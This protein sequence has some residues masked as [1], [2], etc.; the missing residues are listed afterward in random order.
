MLMN[1][2]SPPS[3]L[4]RLFALDP[5]QLTPLER[6]LL[7]TA[8][9]VVVF[10][11][12]R[13]YL[14]IRM[15]PADDLR[16]RVVGARV[17]LAGYEPYHFDWQPGM[18][19]EWLDPVHDPKARR[20]TLSPPMLL[21]YALIAPVPFRLQRYI[22]FVAEWLAMI[23]SLC[24][25]AHSLPAPRHRVIFLLGA[26]VFVIATD[27]WRIHLERGQM[28]VFVLLA[29]SVAIYAA[30]EHPDSVAGGVAFGA[31]ALMRPNLLCILPALLLVRRW[32]CAGAMTATI[33]AGVVAACALLPWSSWP[34]YIAVGDQYFA[35]AQDYDAMP[36]IPRPA[37]EGPVEGMWFYSPMTNFRSNSF[38]PIY[39]F[40]D[41]W[42]N[43]FHVV[44]PAGVEYQYGLPDINLALTSKV[45]MV[46]LA[47]LLSG[48]VWLRRTASP[49]SITAL[50]IVLSLDTEFF[51]PIRWG[52]A[53]M[54]LL[55]P[56]ALFLPDLLEDKNLWLLAVVLLGLLGGPLG[57][58]VFSLDVATVLRSWLVMGGLTALAV[59]AV[60]AP[61]SLSAPGAIG[62]AV[63]NAGH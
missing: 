9:L 41:Q 43:Q 23:A 18:P 51:L 44:D 8:L 33:A 11:I 5:N 49:R 16:N 15:N 36:D 30:R 45:A 32:R 48:L 52:Y 20:L 13:T 63:G 56:L 47:G 58:L 54:V 3:I 39:R 61:S 14:D 37:H 24:L 62:H 25:L 26:V 31:L 55:A 42:L 38:A 57:Q 21:P 53:D 1:A 2:D 12:G 40:I 35:Q 59:F 17:M 7:R 27:I 19:E 22:S 28:Y 6:T 34:G 50:I 60:F 10:V 4:W 29:L 46:S